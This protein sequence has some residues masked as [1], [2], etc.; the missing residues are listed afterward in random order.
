MNPLLKEN[1]VAN[2]TSTAIN[3]L[4]EPLVPAYDVAGDKA[5]SGL[6]A[7]LSNH[8]SS[9]RT[10]LGEMEEVRALI[11]RAEESLGEAIRRMG[12]DNVDRVLGAEL[13]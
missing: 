11:S 3:L 1:G 8:L 2:D 4:S 10:N 5:M 7:D 13:L 12:L 9:I 6:L